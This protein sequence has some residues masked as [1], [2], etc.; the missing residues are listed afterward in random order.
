M[1]SGLPR[2]IRNA[3]RWSV[4]EIPARQVKAMAV[5]SGIAGM[6]SGAFL[7]SPSRPLNEEWLSRCCDCACVPWCWGGT[8]Q[9]G[10]QPHGLPRRA[11]AMGDRAG[12]NYCVPRGGDLELSLGSSDLKRNDRLDIQRH[13]ALLTDRFPQQM[14]V[15]TQKINCLLLPLGNGVR[16]VR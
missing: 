8:V 10:T 5:I 12:P 7:N 9:A 3:P 13:L 4:W 11:G 15:I 16:A 2:G 14:P 1:D 6:V